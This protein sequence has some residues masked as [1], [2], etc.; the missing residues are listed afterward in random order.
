MPGLEELLSSAAAGVE[1][2]L[3]AGCEAL[4]VQMRRRYPRWGAQT[5]HDLLL[6]SIAESA[7]PAVSTIDLILKRHGLIKKRRRVQAYS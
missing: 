6:G 3:A 7:L 4:I 5:I 2:K 1:K